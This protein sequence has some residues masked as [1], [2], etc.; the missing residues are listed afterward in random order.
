MRAGGDPEIG[1]QLRGYTMGVTVVDGVETGLR[2]RR[3]CCVAGR[4]INRAVLSLNCMILR[5]LF[6]CTLTEILY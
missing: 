2:R 5:Q 3:G 4:N 1:R 6:K